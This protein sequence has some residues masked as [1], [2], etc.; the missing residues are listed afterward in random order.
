MSRAIDK[1]TM[2]NFDEA[3]LMLPPEPEPKLEAEQI[4]PHDTNNA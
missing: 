4:E 2:R 1:E 3:C